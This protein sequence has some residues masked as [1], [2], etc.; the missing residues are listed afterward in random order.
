[1]SDTQNGVGSPDSSASAGA[2]TEVVNL[3]PQASPDAAAPI[4]QPISDATPTAQPVKAEEDSD[5]VNLEEL[6]QEQPD[7]SALV[8]H[9]R[10]VLKNKVQPNQ[11]TNN[12]PV[13]DEVTQKKIDLANGLYG[14]DHTTGQ[15][16]TKSFV[17]NV[18]KE[19]P[20]LANQ[21]LFDL[22]QQTME[23]PGY[24]GWTL[25]HELLTR[26]GLDPTKLTELQAYSRGEISP[27]SVGIEA[28]PDYVPTEYREAYKNLNQITRMDLDAYLGPN[29]TDDQ[30]AAALSTLSDKQRSIEREQADAYAEQQ[31][32]QA[33]ETEVYTET[34]TQV[35]ASY[36]GLMKSVTESDAFTQVKLSADPVVDASLKG[37]LMSQITALG[38][39][40]SLLAKQAATSFE[41]MGIK[42]DMA[43]ISSL[44]QEVETN[45]TAAVKADKYGKLKGENYNVQ[46]SDAINRRANAIRSLTAMANSIFSQALARMANQSQ[47]VPQGGLP[48]LGGSTPTGATP[49]NRAKTEKE[50]DAM[51]MGVAG[52]LANGNAS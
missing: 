36:E 20:T 5:T 33:F 32:Q 6:T 22:T 18:V 8:K 21:L 40:R 25:G 1:M 51:I 45:T 13:I 24:N 42:V 15:P 37:N 3:E 12:L 29:G 31:S 46:I 14:L 30:R 16:T 9:L 4:E 11:D 2:S 23:K 43:K 27:Q 49:A 50:L 39:P 35:I 48:N 44:M 26:I 10:T 17:E 28:V 52:S 38:D 7:D 19:S 47:A 34:E 41:A